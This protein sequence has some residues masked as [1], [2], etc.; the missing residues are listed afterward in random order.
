MVEII[1]LL[2]QEVWYRGV[3]YESAP[4]PDSPAEMSVSYTTE[5]SVAKSIINGNRRVYW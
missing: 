5:Y 1:A 4:L 2:Y 3:C